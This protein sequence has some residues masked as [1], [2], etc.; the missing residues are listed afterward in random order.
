MT[1]PS[2]HTCIGPLELGPKNMVI[3]VPL[4]IVGIP[5]PQTGLGTTEFAV[6]E[7]G[8]GDIGTGEVYADI[9]LSHGHGVLDG[10]TVALGITLLLLSPK[11][12]EI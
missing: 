11:K 9:A 4:T 8:T 1:I 12:D 7:I 2:P 6:G 3:G 5:E 10:C